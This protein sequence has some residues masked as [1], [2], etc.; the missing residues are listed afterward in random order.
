MKQYEVDLDQDVLDMLD[1]A[2]KQ[3]HVSSFFFFYWFFIFILGGGGG[4]VIVLILIL[5]VGL[6][7]GEC[8]SKIVL[9]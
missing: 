8:C 4:G 1:A 7:I 2:S 9:G 3:K 6:F 5:C